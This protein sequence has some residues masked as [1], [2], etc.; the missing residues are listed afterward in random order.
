MILLKDVRNVLAAC[1]ARVARVVVE[2]R[3]NLLHL[4]IVHQSAPL[5]TRYAM[6]LEETG[7]CP[8]NRNSIYS[9][10]ISIVRSLAVVP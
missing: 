10:K 6:S 3:P 8:F 5:I 7:A 9:G 4:G 2:N 1:D